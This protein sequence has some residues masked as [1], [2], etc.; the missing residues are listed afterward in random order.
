MDRP[1]VKT[2]ALI[3]ARGGSKGLPGKNIHPLCGKPLIAYTIEAAQQAK[4]IDAVYVSTDDAAIAEVAQAHG[5]LLSAARPAELAND[6]ATTQQVIRHFLDWY[7]DANAAYPDTLVLLQPTS[8]LRTARH[9]DEALQLYHQQAA[10]GSVSVVSVSPGKPLSWQ[11]TVSKT[12]ELALHGFDQQKTNRQQL[13]HNFCLNGA[14]YCT[15]A[16]QAYA[17]GFLAGP[18]YAYVMP[19]EAAVD[20]DTLFDLRLA[21]FLLQQESDDCV[22]KAMPVLR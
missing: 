11:G 9:I 13:A 7:L 5:A 10:K 19:P 15:E 2:V 18:V 8:P 16:E 22:D 12:G 6:T 1:S 14:I 4:T 17:H 3:P 20:I 21:E